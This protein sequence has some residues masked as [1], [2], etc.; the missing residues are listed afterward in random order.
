[1]HGKTE[2]S[3]AIIGENFFKRADSVELESVNVPIFR[4]Y[5]PCYDYYLKGAEML[6][7]AS[8]PKDVI[9]T[10]KP[11][12][13]SLISGRYAMRFPYTP[14]EELIFEFIKNYG[15]THILLDNC[16]AETKNYIFPIAEKHKDKFTV[17][18]APDGTHS[19]ILKLN[20]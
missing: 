20:K 5:V 17:W 8:G 18:V 12:V 4:N 3:F 1:V 10:R 2:S 15:V 9:M 6:T 13:V 11:E 14:K 7:F 19:G 16:Y